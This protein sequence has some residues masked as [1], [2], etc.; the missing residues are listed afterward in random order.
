MATSTFDA[1][2]ASD[3]VAT[4]ALAGA[5]AITSMDGLSTSTVAQVC[6][7]SVLNKDKS[8]HK[9]ARALKASSL[10]WGPRLC[11]KQEPARF[12]QHDIFQRPAT[13]P[14]HPS[15]SGLSSSQPSGAAGVPSQTSTAAAITSLHEARG[16]HRCGFMI[17]ILAAVEPSKFALSPR[18]PSNMFHLT[19]V[20][21]SGSVFA[22]VTHQG[23]AASR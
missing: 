4:T 17:S 16:I 14:V 1:A 6:L 13:S 2:S 19:F 5:K 22:L 10:S 8:L 7:H 21:P 12:Q 23:W 11:Q 18:F 9:Q 3:V 15:F 20:F